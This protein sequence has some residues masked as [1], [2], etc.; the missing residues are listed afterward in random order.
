MSGPGDPEA[1][2][3]DRPVARITRSLCGA[4]SQ[5][6]ALRA[7]RPNW[8]QRGLVG[9]PSSRCP[10]EHLL[11][12]PTTARIYKPSVLPLPAKGR[13]QSSHYRFT[14]GVRN[15]WGRFF[16]SVKEVASVRLAASGTIFEQ[17]V[18]SGHSRPQLDNRVERPHAARTVSPA[19]RQTFALTFPP[20]RSPGR[21]AAAIS[22]K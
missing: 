13:K 22:V 6:P 16:R 8:R 14:R 7:G 21:P 10:T 4:P 5:P 9:R 17:I 12:A 19:R 11:P 15:N 20:R 3:L 1:G 2:A 18:P